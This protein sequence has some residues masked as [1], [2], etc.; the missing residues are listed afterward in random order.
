MVRHAG[1]LI[2]LLVLASCLSAGA[3]PV[4]RSTLSNG[5]TVVAVENGSTPVAGIALLIKT[6]ALAEAQYGLGSRAILQ[7]LILSAGAEQLEGLAEVASAY[8]NRQPRFEV[9]TDYELLE[10]RLS[11]EFSELPAALARMRGL[12]FEPAITEDTVKAARELVH[13]GYDS[14][15]RSPV[16]TT[17]ELFREA[18]Y[19]TGA[20][21]GPLQGNHQDLD[22]VSLQTLQTL[23]ADQYVA[24]NAVLAVVAP[25]PVEESTAAAGAA[26]GD[27]PVKPAPAQPDPPAPPVEALVEVL[28]STDLAQASMVV[29][30]PVAGPTEPD[31]LVGKLLAQLLDGPGGRL[32][33][34]LALLQ[35]LGLVIPSR[36]LAEH[37]PVQT[38]PIP[39]TR[40]PYL[41]VHVLCSPNNIE[42]AR[43]GVLRHFLAFRSGSA[44]DAE[45]ELARKRLINQHSLQYLRPGDA[46]LQ[47]AEREA[48]GM[49][50][51]SDAECAAAVA[52]ISKEDLT[53]FA[54]KHFGR[55][56]IGLQMP[57]M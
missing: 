26:F 56:A 7:Q 30:V 25:M 9:H 53:T 20:L 57:E 41:A 16:Q 46:A 32:Q 3:A 22:R 28:G 1:L 51:L 4:T 48:L 29:G 45:L 44:S 31:Y 5:L 47:L 38:L 37:Y 14:S 23:H 43:R 18:F 21:A 36:L 6:S 50:P 19:E 52:A 27:L 13:E 11:V 24:A 10:A 12:V 40:R 2:A 8:A 39:F 17:Y 33:R 15:H 54:N 49:P 42:R 35:A 34:D 55:H